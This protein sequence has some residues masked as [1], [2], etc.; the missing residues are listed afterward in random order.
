M[1]SSVDN[2]L[3][4]LEGQPTL[5]S[6]GNF[7]GEYPAKALDTLC[8]YLFEVGN[9]AHAHVMRLNNPDTSYLPAFLAPSGLNSGMMIWENV[10]A[11]LVSENKTLVY[12]ASCDSIPT[13]ANKE[14]HVSMGGWSARKAL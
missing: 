3:L 1:N 5:L 13:G 8:L 6:N 10:S 9:L 11:A 14:D 7:H 2:P 12:P 4:F